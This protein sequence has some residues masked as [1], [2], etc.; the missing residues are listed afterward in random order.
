MSTEAQINANNSN[1]QHSTGPKTEAGRAASSQNNFRHGFAGEFRLLAS[2]DPLAYDQLHRNFTIEHQ[3]TTFTQKLLIEKMAQHH[4]LRQR[5]LELQNLTL[6]SAGHRKEKDI[7]RSLALYIRYQTTNERAF[8]KCL[9][10]LLKLRAEKRKEQ[11]GF[12]S[13]Q[14]QKEDHARKQS[15]E[16][17]KQDLHKLNVWLAEA[18]AEHQEFLNHRL[19][20]PET[21]MPNRVQRILARTQAA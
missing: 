5:A 8:G 20:T 1:A 2:E 17:R 12:E 16:I 10:D 19:E 18:K 15:I 11:I 6:E 9:S 7:E 4:W 14:R 3:P 21:R 13:Q